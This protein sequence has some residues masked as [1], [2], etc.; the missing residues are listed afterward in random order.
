[1]GRCSLLDSKLPNTLRNYA[2]QTVA[3][4]RNRCYSRQTKKTAY[5]LFTGKEPNISKMLKFGSVCF[6]YKHLDKRKLDPNCEQGIFVGYDSSSHAYLVYYPDKEKVQKDR[7]VKITIKT[8]KEKE[9]QTCVSYIRY[10]DVEL[11]PKGNDSREIYVNDKVKN[12]P[13]KVY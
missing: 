6:V 1:M 10:G 5:E 13:F 8:G 7:L 12:I 4:V 9:T 2:G 11:H 3:Y